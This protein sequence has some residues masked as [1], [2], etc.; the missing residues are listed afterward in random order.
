MNE[1]LQIFVLPQPADLR[2]MLK[3]DHY[4][5]KVIINKLFLYDNIERISPFLGTKGQLH[6]I[7][8]HM[9]P[10]YTTPKRE[11]CLLTLG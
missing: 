1:H 11:P 2:P 6:S 4:R 7:F 10:V 5:R 9:D 8:E 3:T